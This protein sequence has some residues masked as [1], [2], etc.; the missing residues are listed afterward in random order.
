MMRGIWGI[1]GWGLMIVLEG[2]WFHAIHVGSRGYELSGD[3]IMLV[4]VGMHLQR[5][6]DERSRVHNVVLH[7][8]TTLRHMAWQNES[9][10]VP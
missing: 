3:T 6:N 9:T 8:A 4:A 2:F 10:C 1:R 7:R 5:E